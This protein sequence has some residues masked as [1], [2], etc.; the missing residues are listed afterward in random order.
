MNLRLRMYLQTSAKQRRRT[1]KMLHLSTTHESKSEPVEHQRV[2]D[3]ALVVEDEAPSTVHH[4]PSFTVD[5]ADDILR[6]HNTAHHSTVRQGR[7]AVGREAA[8]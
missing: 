7:Q 8:G 3:G 1:K 6:Q 4:S 5:P 2:R